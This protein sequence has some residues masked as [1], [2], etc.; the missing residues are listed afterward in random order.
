[1]RYDQTRFQL[2]DTDRDLRKSG[3]SNLQSTDIVTYSFEL[4]NK[5]LTQYTSSQRKELGQ[6]L[7]P[8]IVA[9]YMAA[10]LGNLP[11]A[12]HILE[13]AIGSG[14]LACAMIERAVLCQ[15]PKQLFIEGYEVDHD[16]YDAACTALTAATIVSAGLIFVTAFPDFNIF[17]SFADNIA[18]ETEVWIADRPTHL[19]HFNGDRLLGPRPKHNNPK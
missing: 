3:K 13:P 12:C 2:P 7:T 16:L 9:R 8:P 6:F 1:M 17:K 5:I 10:Q 14:V 4:G 15:Q 11:A 19:I 18:Y